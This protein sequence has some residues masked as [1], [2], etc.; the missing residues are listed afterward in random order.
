VNNDRENI[1]ETD[2]RD[3]EM[4]DRNVTGNRMPTQATHT[5]MV[6]PKSEHGEVDQGERTRPETGAGE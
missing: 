4:R 1:R 6:R 5:T 3:N 2:M